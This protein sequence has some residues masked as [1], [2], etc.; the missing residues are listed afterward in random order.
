M[1][2]W[3]RRSKI[4]YVYLSDVPRGPQ[5]FTRQILSADVLLNSRWF[6]RGWTF[7]ELL[8][9][10]ELVFFAADGSEVGPRELFTTVIA[11]HCRIP[12]AVI[13]GTHR[14]RDYNIQ[15]VLQWI[16][17]RQTKRQEDAA[18]CLL[19]VF[20]VHIPL[21]Y[22][23]GQKRAFARLQGQ[24]ESRSFLSNLFRRLAKLI[25]NVEQQVRIQSC[26]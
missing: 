13:R 12:E 14:A 8:A 11:N 5:H 10:K 15:K 23:E 20:G 18:Y 1:Y 25:E 26:H 19:G 6:T 9:P 21:I 16:A 22:G 7:Q 17:Q 24:I 4:C 3:Y 2:E